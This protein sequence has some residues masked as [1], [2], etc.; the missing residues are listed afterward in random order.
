MLDERLN[1]ICACAS[2]NVQ[3]R[4]FLLLNFGDFFR[5]IS[6]ATRTAAIREKSSYFEATYLVAVLTAVPDFPRRREKSVKRVLCA[7]IPQQMNGADKI[8]PDCV[9]TDGKEITYCFEQE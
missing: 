6:V 7:T 5:N 9:P 3:I 2:I 1:E 8:G 4:P